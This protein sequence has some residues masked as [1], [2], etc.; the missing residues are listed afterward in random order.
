MYQELDYILGEWGTNGGRY[1]GLY[2]YAL[3]FTLFSNINNL[4]VFLLYI[5]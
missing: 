2:Y 5:L 1:Y 4:F 3:Y